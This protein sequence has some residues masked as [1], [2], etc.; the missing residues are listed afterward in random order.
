MSG[1]AGELGEFRAGVLA[2]LRNEPAASGERRWNS[3]H[4]IA[5]RAT[6]T[7][8]GVART[9]YSPTGVASVDPGR[10]GDVHREVAGGADRTDVRRPAFVRRP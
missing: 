9:D 5:E 7:S 1:V 6:R 8:L 3:G 4:R 2:A 10:F